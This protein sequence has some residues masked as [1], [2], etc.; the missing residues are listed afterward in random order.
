MAPSVVRAL[1]YQIYYCNQTT[2]QIYRNDSRLEVGPRESHLETWQMRNDKLKILMNTNLL[3]NLG[4]DNFAWQWQCSR[5]DI[6]TLDMFYIIRV[7][8]VD[9]STNLL[10]FMR[11]EFTWWL[12]PNLPILLNL[13]IIYITK[14]SIL[15]SFVRNCTLMGWS[16]PTDKA[17][18]MQQL[19]QQYLESVM[20]A[21]AFKC[22]TTSVY[23]D[24][25][26][27]KLRKLSLPSTELL[28]ICLHVGYESWHF[29]CESIRMFK[30]NV[31]NVDL[32]EENI[33]P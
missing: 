24:P 19:W 1:W 30:E 33:I 9:F 11:I 20:G 15:H 27:Q 32:L 25:L 22:E 28:Q 18:E 26:I 5:H 3:I 7:E 13:W 23:C 14:S 17:R 21:S 16:K 12:L 6:N 29:G 4:D 10:S 2:W 8:W 31:I